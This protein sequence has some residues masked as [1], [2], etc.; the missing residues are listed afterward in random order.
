LEFPA[1][2]YRELLEYIESRYS[3]LYWK[4]L[5]REVAAWSLQHRDCLNSL[6]SAALQQN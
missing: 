5:P 6:G 3:G 1:N 2:Y 4:A